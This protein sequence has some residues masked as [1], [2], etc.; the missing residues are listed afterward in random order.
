MQDILKQH[1]QVILFQ[2]RRGYAPLLECT[3]CGW[4]PMCQN[5]DISLTYHQQFREVIC[6]YCGYKE[7]TPKKCASCGNY[8][9]KMIGFGTEKIEDELNIFFPEYNSLRMD[10]DTTRGKHAYSRIIHAFEDGEAQI[11]IGTQMVTKGLDFENVRLVGILN[12]DQ[13]LRYPDFRAIERSYQMI[14]QVSGRAG[15]KNMQGKVIIQ[16]Y[17]VHHPLFG[18]VMEHNYE[19]FYESHIQERLDYQYPPFYRLIKLTFRHEDVEKVKTSAHYFADRLRDIFGERILGP[20]FPVIA[21]IRGKYAMNILMKFERQNLNMIEAKQ[22]LMKEV[23]SYR[24]DK[25]YNAVRIVV[26]VDP[27]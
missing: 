14:S 3:T 12:A 22:T 9:L 17:N 10:Q 18:Y 26:D 1:G 23:D 13:M 24:S 6:H 7:E 11:L 19:G 15:R 2:N 21:R 4:T 20:E 5:C 25:A 27:Y 16:T 8:T